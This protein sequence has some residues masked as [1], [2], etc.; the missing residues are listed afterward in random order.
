[1][2]EFEVF[3]TER[4][5]HNRT[6]LA[7]KRHNR[8]LTSNQNVGRRLPILGK[9]RAATTTSSFCSKLLPLDHVGTPYLYP[10]DQVRC[11]THQQLQH[12]WSQQKIRSVYA[13]ANTE[14]VKNGTLI[15][16]NKKEQNVIVTSKKRGG[17]LIKYIVNEHQQME[18][19]N[20]SKEVR[21][22]TKNKIMSN[23]NTFKKARTEAT[24]KSFKENRNQEVPKHRYEDQ[25]GVDHTDL[26]SGCLVSR[27]AKKRQNNCSNSPSF[28]CRIK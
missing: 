11:K 12:P 14:T 7:D 22:E 19:M 27:A 28:I 17:H 21:M 3:F 13:T 6:D 20:I 23:K 26:V 25:T 24:V 15:A 18:K 9:P 2:C 5:Q 8:T 1:M 4:M 16:N 10:H